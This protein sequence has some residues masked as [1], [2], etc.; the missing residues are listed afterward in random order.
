MCTYGWLCT[1]CW[2]L[3]TASCNSTTHLIT[4][5]LRIFRMQTCTHFLALQNRPT[6]PP[7]IGEHHPPSAAGRAKVVSRRP[8]QART[9]Q[10]VFA[11][12][13]AK[14]REEATGAAACRSTKESRVVD[15]RRRAQTKRRLTDGL[16]YTRPKRDSDRTIR[17]RKSDDRSNNSTRST[18]AH[19]QRL[20]TGRGQVTICSNPSNPLFY[21]NITKNCFLFC[22]P[23]HAVRRELDILCERAHATERE[24]VCV[25]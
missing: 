25:C 19:D 5:P 15:R 23:A 14:A 3:L 11:H 18:G 6:A 21:V 9:D 24:R 4:P 20:G 12:A 17:A 22:F 1:I 7:P 2:F 16:M 10:Q 8:R 13:A